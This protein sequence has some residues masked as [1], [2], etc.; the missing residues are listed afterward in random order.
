MINREE[1]FLKIISKTLSNSGFLGD[2][3]AYLPEY[4]LAVSSDTLVQD[5]HFN[6]DTITPEV[7]GKKSL[8]VN[9]SDILSSGAK[10]EYCTVSLSGPLNNDFIKCFYTG[11]NTV[12]K[13]FDI[14]VIGGDLTGGDKI[15][16]SI[17]ILGNTKDRSISS[18]SNAKPG[19]TVFLAGEHGS[20]AEGL[21]FL[22]NKYKKTEHLP[23]KEDVGDYF[24]KAH[25]EPKLYP[26]ISEAASLCAHPYAMM[27]TSDGL[28]DALKK[29]SEASNVGFYIE[30]NK[31]P[32]K[33]N[34][35][36]TVL[37]GGE[38]YGL[39][40]CLENSDF[41]KIKN[42]LCGK[43]TAIIGK[44]T[45]ETRILIDNKEVLEDL[46]FGHFK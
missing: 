20:S 7:L 8:L 4:N 19:Y 9:I 16:V 17:T 37:F 24:I 10:P 25:L 23:Y 15:S 13:E 3:C 2:D 40:I 29:I 46:R 38:D 28:Y 14:V 21:K 22:T 31:I 34:D 30:F 1:N 32:K 45:K 33:I 35:F 26:K 12:C 27:D 6:L 41:E 44:V 18:R 5:V 11:I 42:D 39:L 43:N 36:N